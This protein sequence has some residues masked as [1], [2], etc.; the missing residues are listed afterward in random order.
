MVLLLLFERLPHLSVR[1]PVQACQ[2]VMVVLIAGQPGGPLPLGFLC[3]DALQLPPRL[4]DVKL[5]GK[6]ELGFGA[7]PMKQLG[8]LPAPFKE[9][10]NGGSQWSTNGVPK[11]LLLELLVGLLPCSSWYLVLGPGL[12]EVVYGFDVL[13]QDLITGINVA[14]G[15]DV[16][17]H[18]QEPTGVVAQVFGHAIPQGC[19]VARRQALTFNSPQCH[20]LDASSMEA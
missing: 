8:R 16:I 1:V 10:D 19:S 11:V 14:L 13:D 2:Q 6:K 9:V 3:E 18:I 15:M 7:S 5:M 12:N 20:W 17:G 4:L